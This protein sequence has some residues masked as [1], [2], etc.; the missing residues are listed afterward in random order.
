MIENERDIREEQAIDIAK[1]MMVAART[2]PKGK[3]V[4]IIEC[5]VVSGEDIARISEELEQ[6]FAETNMKFYLRDAN[7]IKQAL[8][9]VLVGTRE[10]AQGLNCARCGYATCDKRPEGVPCEINSVDVGIALG[11]ACAKASDYFEYTGVMFSAGMSAAR[12]CMLP[13]C[14]QVYAIPISISSKNP[15]F[16]RQTSPPAQPQSN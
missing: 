7:N 16:D 15:F 11:A 8:C 3:G 4:D 13:G 1:K 14:A 9:I 2:A 6:L 10:H 5:A 12:C